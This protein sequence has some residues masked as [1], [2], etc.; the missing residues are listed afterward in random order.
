ML[1]TI[2]AHDLKV[3]PILANG[4]PV[5]ESVLAGWFFAS[6]AGWQID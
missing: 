6:L 1:A 2:S 5:I 4:P 3:R